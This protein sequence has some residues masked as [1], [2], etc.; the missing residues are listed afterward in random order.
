MKKERI[1]WAGV[2]IILISIIV[3]NFSI[4]GTKATE[5]DSRK[6]L[7]LFGRVFDSLKNSYIEKKES[8]ELIVGA[9][10]GMIK[11]LNDPH[12]SFL[13]P[14]EKE[15]LEIETTGEYGGLGIEI[16]IRD[17]K[18]TVISPIEDTPA[19]KAGIKSGDR[20]VKIEGE[21]VVDPDLGKIVEKL[22]GKPQTKVT[23]SIERE[24]IDEL[25]D[26]T[27]MREVI[28]IKSVKSDLIDDI[29]YIRLISFRK[30]AS[31]E[32]KSILSR[33]INKK[34]IKGIIIDLRNNPGG[35]LD[36]AISISDLFIDKGLIVYTKPREDSLPY[37][38]ALNKKF[39]SQAAGTIPSNIPIVLLVNHGSASASE[40]LSG[41]IKDHKRG[42]LLGTKTFGKGSVQSVVNLNDG[43]GLRY[44]TAYYYTP[45]GTKIHNI[46]IDPDIELDIPNLSKDEIKEIAKLK[47]KDL[48]QTFLKKNKNPEKKE[49]DKFISEIKGNQVNLDERILNRIIK[50]EIYRDKKMPLYDLDWDIQLKM[51]LDILKSEISGILNR[52]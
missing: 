31:L 26:F 45:N 52:N 5:D 21:S 17:N 48:I 28:K 4:P 34:K 32:L 11:T 29:A 20:I 33:Y 30:N 13:E 46:G 41:A 39:Y 47:E 51:A 14:K 44:T 37:Y 1:I 38:S 49:I 25:I 35:L 6:Y 8:R 42:I 15:N 27:I 36:V 18:L 23:V 50:Q 22:R 2:V 9:I 43:Y 10:N 16:G 12:T 40:I 7:D 19:E 24:G 3:I